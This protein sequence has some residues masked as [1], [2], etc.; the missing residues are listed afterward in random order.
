MSL[1]GRLAGCAA[2]P[3]LLAGCFDATGPLD[4]PRIEPVTTR[5]AI[6]EAQI[7]LLSS[8]GVP[9]CWGNQPYLPPDSFYIPGNGDLRLISISGNSSHFCGLTESGELHCW[10]SNQSG[11]LGDGTTLRRDQIYPNAL[12]MS[13]R[14]PT[15]VATDLRFAAVSTTTSSTCA[16]DVTG[17]AW[18]WGRNDR[19][20]LGTTTWGEFVRETRPVPVA[21]P[22]RFTDI[23]G[24]GYTMCALDLGRRVHCWGNANGGATYQLH[25]EPGVCTTAYYFAY[26]GHPCMTPTPVAGSV[27]FSALSHGRCGL[28]TDQRIWCWGNGYFGQFGNGTTAAYSVPPVAAASDVQ[29][30]EVSAGLQHTCAIALDGSAWCWGDNTASQLGTGSTAPRGSLPAPVLTNQRFVT[31]ATSS[32]RTCG[33]TVTDEVWCWGSGHG[34]VPVR[35]PV[36]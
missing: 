30:R 5:L 13:A 22:Q 32:I 3:L 7:C 27:P 35:V 25:R 14:D 33:L 21:T 10:G 19:G 24:G 1:Y 4:P 26:D 29:F 16:L 28:S 6:S 20:V 36:S 9:R 8:D 31:L 15:P 17:K 18:C 34:N 12:G 11:E 2:L 23:A